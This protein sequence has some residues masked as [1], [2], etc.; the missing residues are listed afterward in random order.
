MLAI[1]SLLL[2][3]VSTMRMG[4]GFKKSWLLWLSIP[5]WFEQV[6]VTLP[7]KRGWKSNDTT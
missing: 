2:M 3:A 1:F 6:L 7:V 4:Y 5:F